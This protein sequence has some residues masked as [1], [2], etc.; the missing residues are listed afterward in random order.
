MDQS[1]VPTMKDIA[2]SLN[3]SV[4]TIS[5]V[6]NGHKDISE[7]T[8]VEVWNKIKEIGYTPN[9]LA[10][11]LRRNHSNVVVLVLSDTSKPYFARVIKG[12]EETLNAAGYHTM[13]FSSMEQAEKEA[14]L[15][16]QIS[17]MNIAGIIIDPAQN[18]DPEQ[19]ALKQTGIPYVFSSR[20]LDPINDYYVSA[21]N[22]KVGY[23]ATKYL[24]ERK[25]GK[26]VFCVL[27]PNNVSP[28]HGRYK[29]Y[30]KAMLEANIEVNENLVI[31]NNFSLEDAY[32]AGEKIV[33]MIEDECSIFCAT[34]QLAIGVMRALHDAG[35][36]IPKQAAIIGV[37]DIDAS[38]YLTPSLSTIAIPKEEIGSKSA[39]M[40]IKLIEG[41]KVD[42]RQVLLEPELII[43]ETT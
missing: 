12:Y 16:N 40:L 19:K 5:K 36:S 4:T 11:N 25:P 22:E 26:P 35:V 28:T 34:D 43:R 18:S 6:I 33:Q 13:I 2:K 3:V 10:A 8:K 32:K 39:E 42:I 24:L 9:F 21:D 15:I 37:D 14:G 41:K 38:A 23:I 1:R 27:T 7:K 20:Y 31:K 29:G 17:S 30:C